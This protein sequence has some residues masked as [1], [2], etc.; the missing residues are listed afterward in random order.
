MVQRISCLSTALEDLNTL[1][2]HYRMHGD[3]KPDN[4]IL[5]TENNSMRLIDFDVSHKLGIDKDCGSTPAFIDPDTPLSH[6]SQDLYGMGKVIMEL[7]PELYVF[8]L[9]SDLR[10]TY[11]FWKQGTLSI[12]EQSIVNLVNALSHSEPQMRCTSEDALH[13]CNDLLR[14]IDTLDEVGLTTLTESK[15]RRTKI[16]IED[17]LRQRVP[18]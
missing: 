4:F 5:N 10:A 3:V 2:N 13:Y 12:V 16:T 1:H 15:L 17:V 14:S 7:F 9:S 11:S 18:S 6:L 8:S